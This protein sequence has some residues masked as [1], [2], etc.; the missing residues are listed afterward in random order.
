M[1]QKQLRRQTAS[2]SRRVERE[3][4]HSAMMA[5]HAQRRA[6]IALWEAAYDAWIAADCK[7]PRPIHPHR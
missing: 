3:I 7:G 4:A 5:A 1:T 6:E 2:L